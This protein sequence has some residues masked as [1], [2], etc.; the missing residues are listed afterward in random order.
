MGVAGSEASCPPTARLCAKCSD[1]ACTAGHTPIENAAVTYGTSGLTC[2]EAA[3]NCAKGAGATGVEAPFNCA[4]DPLELAANPPATPAGGCA[5]RTCTAAECC[6]VV[7]IT[8]TTPGDNAAPDGTACGF[9]DELNTHANVC[10]DEAAGAGFSCDCAVGYSGTRTLNAQPTDCAVDRNCDAAYAPLTCEADCSAREWTVSV[11]ASGTGTCDDGVNGQTWPCTKSD[12]LCLEISHDCSTVDCGEG[13][14]CS[15]MIDP[16][17]G[18]SAGYVCSCRTAGWE[19]VTGSSSPVE[20]GAAQ[21]QRKVGC[22]QSYRPETCQA[23]CTERVWTSEHAPEGHG[24][25]ECTYMPPIPCIKG[26]GEC[27]EID[28]CAAGPSCGSDA[29][30]VDTV[31]ANAGTSSGYSCVC[32]DGYGGDTEPNTQATCEIT[33]N[34]DGVF[35]METT[36][37]ATDSTVGNTTCPSTCGMKI[38]VITT[39]ANGGGKTCTETVGFEAG[40]RTPCVHGD[41]DCAE[42]DGC[43]ALAADPET[44]S[45]DDLTCP[46]SDGTESIC[47]DTTGCVYTAVGSEVAPAP[48]RCDA[49]AGE[50]CAAATDDQCTLDD[51]TIRC[52]AAETANDASCVVNEEVSR[53]S[54]GSDSVELLD[55]EACEAVA[56]LDDAAA[57]E[58]VLTSSQ[59]DTDG[60][61]V[62]V[63]NPKVEPKDCRYVPMVLPVPATDSCHA[64]ICPAVDGHSATCDAVV[65]CVY[66]GLSCGGHA[67]CRDI[68]DVTLGADSG[69]ECSCDGGYASTA[70]DAVNSE[71]EGCSFLPSAALEALV[72][73]E[74]DIATISVG[75]EERAIFAS[76][77]KSD[78]ASMLQI[79]IDRVEIK[80]IEAGSV[81]VT[82]YVLP[83]NNH[84][85]YDAATFQLKA[86]Q[87]ESGNTLLAG[88]TALGLTNLDEPFFD[89]FGTISKTLKEGNVMERLILILAMLLFLIVTYICYGVIISWCDQLEKSALGDPEGDPHDEGEG[90]EESTELQALVETSGEGDT[91]LTAGGQPAS[92]V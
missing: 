20:N 80:S 61:K 50:A 70:A 6:T 25:A 7:P 9:E 86:E 53:T 22:E 34:C 23:D 52:T 30:C 81:V 18:T 40:A 91:L 8:C 48:E 83:D 69:Y 32:D 10:G 75:T 44:C 31:D 49:C 38:F 46:A 26:T 39:R 84:V 19:P 4:D 57:C 67:H 41:G 3:A 74:F 37:D 17:P 79:H 2:C 12:G 5:E 78:V 11:P 42:L 82:F 63:Y 59:T 51:S 28:A 73:L 87:M 21:C 1:V 56:G 76:N 47:T 72:T 29:H 88:H 58:A 36:V 64:P 27:L 71:K 15:D 85:A 33:Q 35:K 60:V 43:A 14:E 62:C 55:T 54:G 13:T 24:V 16:V 92:N 45:S 90:L 77:F 66:S 65:G 68:P 89:P